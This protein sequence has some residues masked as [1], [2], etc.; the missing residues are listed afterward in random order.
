VDSSL[1]CLPIDLAGEGIAP[2][3]ANA[4]D[5]AGVAGV[6]LAVAYH[7]ARDVLPHNPL[8]RV[9]YGGAGVCFRPDARRYARC[10][11]SPRISGVAGDR[12]VLRELCEEAARRGAAVHAWT[13]F[14]HDDAGI[15]AAEDAQVRNVYGDPN[16][17]GLCPANEAVRDYAVALTEDIF[18]YPVT[19][20]LAEALS[21]LPFDHGYHHERAFVVLPPAARL[22]LGACFCRSCEG[23]GRR[24][25][26]DVE[27]VRLA[28]RGY[29]GPLLAG[30]RRDEEPLEALI[31]SLADGE[32]ARYLTVRSEQVTTLVA[33]VCSAARAAGR[34]LTFLDLS[35]GIKG[36][37]DGEPSGAP[38]GESAWHL[39]IDID[40]IG[41]LC[42]VSV[43]AYA[44]SRERVAAELAYYAGR[45]GHAGLGALLRPMAPDCDS[46]ENLCAKL[47]AVRAAGARRVDFYS[48]GFMPL[49][50]LDWIAAAMDG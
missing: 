1:F 12:D 46:A 37:S 10:G 30:T 13:V 3:V 11:L 48:Y 40:A 38:G 22:L 7:D 39:G 8:R 5:R 50:S 32:L 45:P 14:L 2:V 26:V 47:D 24:A 17:T 25:G 6:S 16:P 41:R 43:P 18:R 9:S 4:V 20:I 31:S 34:D 28:V 23:A 44:R 29:L 27:H 49:G 42:P 35:A 15:G 33:A 36:W 19:S 21:Y